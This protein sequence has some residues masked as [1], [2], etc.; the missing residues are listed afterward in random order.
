MMMMMMSHYRRLYEGLNCGK[1]RVM[2]V[3]V[4]INAP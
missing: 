4:S 2:V 3:K 1:R